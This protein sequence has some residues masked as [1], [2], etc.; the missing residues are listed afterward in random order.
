MTPAQA[1]YEQFASDFPDKS[2]Y[3]WDNAGAITQERW[4]LIAQAALDAHFRQPVH[5]VAEYYDEP[6]DAV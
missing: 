4:A 6:A 3:G 1:A 2:L 5:D